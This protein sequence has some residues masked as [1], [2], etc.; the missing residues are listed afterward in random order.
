MSDQSAGRSWKLLIAG[1]L[2]SF[3]FFQIVTMLVAK[4]SIRVVEKNYYSEG[5]RYAEKIKS[6]KKASGWK[7]TPVFADGK[8]RVLATE[9]SQMP[10]IGAEAVFTRLPAVGETGLSFRLTETAPG[11]Y[12]AKMPF[13]GSNAAE[14]IV[15]LTRGDASASVK[16][17]PAK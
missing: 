17:I 7:I 16:V 14:V 3:A 5:L 12:V 1:I 4:K 9:A 8:I 13:Y 6:A 11:E 2:I 15:T 10:L